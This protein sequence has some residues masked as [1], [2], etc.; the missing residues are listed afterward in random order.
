MQKQRSAEHDHAQTIRVQRGANRV[1]LRRFDP[2]RD[3]YEQLTLMLHRAFERLAAM[4]LHCT[5]VDQTAALTR[6]R[7][8]AGDCFVAVCNGRL[9]GTMTLHGRDADSSCEH[10]RRHDVA[11]LRQ[12]GVHP[13]WQGRGIGKLMLAFAEHW[14]ATRGYAQLALDTPYPAGHLVAF[15]RTRGFRIVDVVHFAGKNYESAILAKTP[16]AFRPFA[17]EPAVRPGMPRRTLGRAA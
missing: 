11:T 8:L 16:V 6:Q 4:G 5:C 1:V 3:S 7:V 9:V 15:Y 12:L 13:S 2:A 17:H 14:A 10:Y